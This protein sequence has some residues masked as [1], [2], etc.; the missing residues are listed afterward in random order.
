MRSLA[1][2]IE[3]RAADRTLT[4]EEAGIVVE[5]IVD[6]ARERHGAVLRAG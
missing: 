3:L 1:F 6:L 2:A 5:R 4:D